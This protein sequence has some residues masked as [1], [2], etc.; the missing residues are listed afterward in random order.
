[1]SFSHFVISRD[2][3]RPVLIRL[4]NLERVLLGFVSFFVS[5]TRVD[6]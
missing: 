1:M 6:V 3:V 4:Y 5:A 2:I